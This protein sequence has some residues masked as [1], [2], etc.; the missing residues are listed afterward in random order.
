MK[1]IKKVLV[2]LNPSSG[3]AGDDPD[4]TETNLKTLLDSTHFKY[5]II[6]TKKNEDVGEVVRG[7]LTEGFDLVIAAGGDGTVSAV[8]NGLIGTL[9]PLGI[10][11]FGT[12][13][14][15]AKE[16]NIPQEIKDAVAVI[17]NSPCSKK[18]DAMKIGKRVFVLNAS[19]GYSPI[20]LR[21]TT[22]AQK[23]RFGNLAYVANAI[24]HLFRLRFRGFEIT[25][26]GKLHTSRAV[27]CIV[28]NSGALA[29]TMYPKGPDVKLDD[30]HLDIWVLSVK[31]VLDYPRYLFYALKGRPGRLLTPLVKAEKTVSVKSRIS[32]GVQ[33][34]G[35]VIG[36][37]PLEIEIIP[38][39]LT[40]LVPEAV[41]EK[42]GSK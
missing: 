11:P 16:L 32:M 7:R 14:L 6:L 21:N 38:G 28:F 26:D 31:T 15:L 42:E 12:G 35:D 23:N 29:R 5:E 10:V 33:A 18:I 13:N 20:I 41:I 17:S 36:K 8:I 1:K 24:T 30:G 19:A 9:I 3:K 37:T 4:A 27:E 2:V 39:A 22:T 40:V 34:D 25:I